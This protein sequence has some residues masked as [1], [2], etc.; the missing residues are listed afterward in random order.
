YLNSGGSSLWSADNAQFV[1]WYWCYKEDGDGVDGQAS[2]FMAIVPGD[3]NVYKTTLNI[4]EDLTLS[5]YA[6]IFLRVNSSV[7]SF[8]VDYW[9]DL[10]WNRTDELWMIDAGEY[11]Y[12]EITS[13]YGDE[14]WGLGGEAFEYNFTDGFWSSSYLEPTN[15]VAVY[16]YPTEIFLGETVD[17]TGM[18]IITSYDFNNPTITYEVLLPS[19]TEYTAINTT[20][21]TP[22]IA[23]DYIFRITAT[24]DDNIASA[25]FTVGV[26]NMTIVIQAYRY[27]YWYNHLYI[28]Y[29]VN[30]DDANNSGIVQ[31]EDM[32]GDWYSYE[33]SGVYGDYINVIF[34]NGS[35]WDGNVN[36][37]V[38]SDAI[39]QSTSYVIGESGYPD[40]DDWGKHYLTPVTNSG[41]TLSVNYYYGDCIALHAWQ[42]Y[43]SYDSYNYPLSGDWPG[44]EGEVVSYSNVTWRKL[45]FTTQLDE[46]K[47]YTYVIVN[48]SGADTQTT[49]IDLTSYIYSDDSWVADDMEVWVYATGS[50]DSDYTVTLRGDIKSLLE[51]QY[52]LYSYNSGENIILNDYGVTYSDDSYNTYKAAYDAASDAFGAYA[53]TQTEIDDAVT[54]LTNAYNSLKKI[55]TVDADATI[56]VADD[57]DIVVNELY[58]YSDINNVAKID[59]SAASVYVMDALTITKTV[60]NA[61]YYYFS[62]PFDCAVSDIIAVDAEGNSLVDTDYENVW[63]VRE[64][65][66]YERAINWSSVASGTSVGWQYVDYDATLKANQGYLIGFGYGG[67]DYSDRSE[68]ASCG[69]TFIYNGALTLKKLTEVAVTATDVESD[70]VAAQLHKGY[71]LISVPS[72]AV[73]DNSISYTASDNSDN[74]IQYISVSYPNSDGYGYTQFSTLEG[75]FDFEPFLPFFVQVPENGTLD[76]D[77]DFMSAQ[78]ASGAPMLSP[79]AVGGS[80][81]DYIVVKLMQNG[82]VVDKTTA[83]FVE[84]DVTNYTV[85]YDLE[86]MFSSAMPQIYI[87]DKGYDLAVNGRQFKESDIITLEIYTPSAGEY[88]ISLTSNDY[89]I[90]DINSGDLSEIVTFTTDAAGYITG[91]YRVVRQLI[92]T[93]NGCVGSE[94]SDLSI[95]TQKGSVVV[96]NIDTSSPIYL[97]TSSGQLVNLYTST[98]PSITI[99]GLN[100]G[101]YLLRVENRTYKLIINN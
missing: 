32:G 79:S 82:E 72:Y 80:Q 85:G 28:Y 56:S 38:N 17:F 81:E 77:Y 58:L 34:V 93:D 44:R 19:A 65:S 60:D 63:V 6:I 13:W 15:V 101:I 88:T 41:K 70:D 29:W 11:N 78:T 64:Y 67:T 66:E 74:D 71:N 36:Q 69:F 98:Q 87:L 92:T 18:D 75:G 22:N 61:I 48:N 30:G 46:D 54:T 100:S 99:S 68:V 16:N 8:D 86:K 91:E 31:M 94:V 4:R 57:D 37:T 95:Y 35:D 2:D 42:K 27:D 14:Y 96:E 26:V 12:F 43:D 7:T 5:E 33:Y 49:D 89:M 23:G 25:E 76:F 10:V 51:N 62:L 39:Y 40:G 84:K 20:T 47:Q 24:E 83:I 53:S 45:D 55:L 50:G 3:E 52:Y 1:V 90:E 73:Y 9:D 97:Y 21:Y 59:F